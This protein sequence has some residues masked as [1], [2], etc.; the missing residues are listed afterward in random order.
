M[1]PFK[2]SRFGRNESDRIGNNFSFAAR[3]L[4]V[5]KKARKQNERHLSH[6]KIKMEY[7]DALPEPNSR[8]MSPV[9]QRTAVPP[10]F[11]DPSESDLIRYDHFAQSIDSSELEPLDTT[12]FDSIWSVSP[13]AQ[14]YTDTQMELETEIQDDYLKATKCSIV[15]YILMEKSEQKRL[16]INI[17]PETLCPVTIRAPVP[18]RS[19]F[20]S[21]S[22]FCTENLHTTSETIQ[23]LNDL[24]HNTFCDD[25]FVNFKDG[26][27]SPL[28]PHEF[29]R[30]ISDHADETR[31]RLVNEW[32]PTCADIVRD[33]F[34]KN[35]HQ[36][37][38]QSL[39]SA[40]INSED[41]S[42]SQT[43]NDFFNCVASLMQLQVRNLVRDSL[44]LLVEFLLRYDNPVLLKDASE[45]DM[46]DYMIQPAIEIRLLTGDIG[47]PLFYPTLEVVKNVVANCFD[48]IVESGRGLPRIETILFP[49]SVDDV[50]ILSLSSVDIHEDW[51]T[52]LLKTA[53][54]ILSQHFPNIQTYLDT[55]IPYADLL[56]GKEAEDV[57]LFIHNSKNV[58]IEDIAIRIDQI[59]RTRLNIQELDRD[60]QLGLFFIDC[61]QLNDDL[62]ELTRQL[63]NQIIQ[64]Q[65]DR[66]RELNRQINRDYE[67]IGRRLGKETNDT[68]ELVETIKYLKEVITVK[69]DE[70]SNR[71]QSSGIRL[72]F[73][74]LYANLQDEDYR[75][76]SNVF[77]Q[78]EHLRSTL[79][80]NEEKFQTKK[81]GAEN[82]V[83][84]KSKTIE[85]ELE[86]IGRSIDGY[87][88]EETASSDEI[89][90][91]VTALQTLL[92]DLENV[93]S[94][95]ENLNFEE[96]LLE[97]EETT[98]PDLQ[99]HG[100]NLQPYTQLWETAQKWIVKSEEWL[101]GTFAKIDPEELTEELQTM[102]RLMYKLIKTFNDS[103]PP[104]RM[105]ETVK[106]KIDKFKKDLPVI[107]ALG[108]NGM[109]K[110]HWDQIEEIVG[111][112]IRPDEDTTLLQM[113]EYNLNE[114]IHKLEEV[115]ASAA[116]EYA[117]ERTLEKMKED[118]VEMEFVL[119]PYRDTVILCFISFF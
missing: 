3:D 54:N 20:Q 2:E 100:K 113:L 31:Q 95:I 87:G 22:D 39:K 1:Q 55:Y 112:D 26:F 88:S 13:L 106:T 78:P 109:R 43:I 114:Y 40:H 86:R 29:I 4:K 94:S 57:S 60:C 96:K 102:W 108:A 76:N 67:E 28:V 81:T 111:T 72:E 69:K 48:Y 62:S 116:K 93:T 99:E 68:E 24:W 117:L 82:A 105:A 7:K 49:E 16:R 36:Y 50:P 8:P 18:W 97:R 53:D 91:H 56:S 110:R 75:L 23:Q 45:Y 41:N 9:E 33:N 19:S 89:N 98:Y 52:G 42:S 90:R 74:I 118:W 46:I 79:D 101:Q 119:L 58:E 63:E 27:D 14:T 71:V 61:I 11:I 51:V 65:L 15:D 66:N 38:I 47:V 17:P 21:S 92:E 59:R 10:S 37:N 44:K 35:K 34:I 12:S 25:H 30:A 103:P 77:G 32:I 70:L 115:S 85:I 80:Y 73:L 5:L 104:R 84:Q 107:Q 64:D 83:R 6:R